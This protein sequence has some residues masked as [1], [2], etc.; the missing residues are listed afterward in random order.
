LATLGD[1]AK[2]LAGGQSLVPLLNLRLARP[3]HLVDINN[4]Q[5]LTTIGPIDGGGLRIGALVRQRAAE[6]SNLVQQYCPLMAEA[7]PMIGHPQIR[8]RG[9]IG[10]SLAHA[11]PASELP[12]VAAALDADLVVRSTKGQRMLKPADFF[13]SYLTTSVA[14][15]ELVVE[16]RLPA[17]SSGTGWAFL[18]VSRRLG[19][20][21]M[22]GVASTLRLAPDGSIAEAR[23]AYTGVGSSPIR[24]HD[25][26]RK[27]IGQ[28]AAEATFV[29]A[30]E[31]AAR[32]L[33]PPADIHA[34]A[35]YRRHVTKTLTRRAL[36]L[37]TTR[38]GASKNGT[39]GAA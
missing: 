12:A 25:A 35:A 11:D 1:E 27:L 34:T 38:A 15:D 26:E 10:G 21:A 36:A 37:A 31:E 29:A 17:W 13:V 22:V 14:A 4:L 23:L 6:R 9:T 2:V 30:G 28:P 18:E 8:N 32:T 3:A 24:A 5:E 20:F 33:D 16:L 39:G 7:L 19:D